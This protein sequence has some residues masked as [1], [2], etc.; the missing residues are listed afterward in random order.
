MLFLADCFFYEKY[1]HYSTSSI[2]NYLWFTPAPASN[3]ASRGYQSGYAL[4]G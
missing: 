4:I 1:D 2:Y 3:I